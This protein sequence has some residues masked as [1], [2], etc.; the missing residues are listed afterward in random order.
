MNL[1]LTLKLKG[2]RTKKWLNPEDIHNASLIL[3]DC[4]V[5][6]YNSGSITC[7]DSNSQFDIDTISYSQ[8]ISKIGVEASTVSVSDIGERYYFDVTNIAKSWIKNQIGEGGFSS[9]YGLILRGN[10][11]INRRFYKNSSGYNM[12]YLEIQHTYTSHLKN[13]IYKISSKYNGNFMQYNGASI[14]VTALSS[15]L[16]D[17]KK[18]KITEV[19]DGRYTIQPINNENQYLSV[20]SN[21]TGTNLSISSTRFL[22]YIN[23]NSDGTYR[24]MPYDPVNSSNGITYSGGS[25]LLNSYTNTSYKKWY[26]EPLYN[27]EIVHYYDNG[28]DVRFSNAA[29]NIVSYQDVVSQIYM[30][31]FGLN[32]DSSVQK[33]VSCADN[34][35]GLPINYNDTVSSCMHTPKHKTRNNIFTDLSNQFG[36]GTKTLSKVAWPGHVLDTDSSASRGSTNT[37]VLTIGYVTDDSNINKPED[38]IRKQRIY[39]LLHE[40]SHQLGAPDHYCYNVNSNNCSNPSGDC[41]RCDRGL[42]SPPICVM[43][44]RW[45]D[46][47]ERLENGNLDG[48][49]CA[50]CMSAT[51]SKGIL[52]HLND[53]HSN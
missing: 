15:N 27:Y 36:N 35:S 47:E 30:N 45:Y 3:T 9:A 4:T 26:I 1:Y 16:S 24:I 37:I 49:Y 39:T 22:W 21:T 5:G 12:P 43:T 50:Q 25:V 28:Y 23:K 17:I 10:S 33:Y 34:C 32:V 46:L 18:W 41:W 40:S 44:S 48:I 14:N 53:H 29:N 7:Y 6:Y 38:E 52:T 42:S 11:V 19:Y 13:G 20:S 8:L 51:D 2:W 31:V